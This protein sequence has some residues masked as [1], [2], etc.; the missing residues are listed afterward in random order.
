MKTYTG[1][2]TVQEAVQEHALAHAQDLVLMD[3]ARLVQADAGQTV[4]IVA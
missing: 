1:Q 3:A 4:Q 2:I